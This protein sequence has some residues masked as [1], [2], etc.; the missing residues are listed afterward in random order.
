MLIN[1]K[2]RDPISF[3]EF[4]ICLEA[5]R[6]EKRYW[7]DIWSYREL[8][9]ILAWRDIAVRYKQTL[10]GTT[11][12]IMQPFLSM[13]IM[14]FIFGKVAGLPSEG[15]IPYAIMV[16]A[17]MLPWQFFANA[18]TTSGQSIVGNANLISKV[19]FPRLIIPTSAIAVACVDLLVSFVILVGMMFWYRFIPSWNLIGL[20]ILILMS[21]LTALGPGLIITA[22]NVKYRDFRF[23]IPFLIQFGMYVSPVAYS[24]SVIHNKLG[25]L[26]FL[27]YSLNPMVGIIDCFRWA[28]LGNNSTIYLPSFCTSIGMTMIFLN[29]GIWYFRKTEKTFADII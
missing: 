18:I 15:N 14:T 6:A 29:V 3:E 8:L 17:G 28:I 25:T 7:L 19:Y 1:L 10:V 2:V 4:D 9:Q 22:L 5:G 16:F 21:F 13:L 23:V 20:P 11:W 24:S 26:K 12:A 27:I